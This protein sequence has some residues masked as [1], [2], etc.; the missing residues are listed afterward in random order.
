[1]VM[2]LFLRWL[3]VDK[4]HCILIFNHPLDEFSLSQ[5]LC[6]GKKKAGE[7]GKKDYTVRS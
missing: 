5:S 2:T 3:I 6:E 1:M 7:N 4:T